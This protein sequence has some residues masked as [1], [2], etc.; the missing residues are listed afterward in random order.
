MKIIRNIIIIFVGGIL[1]L[2]VLNIGNSILATYLLRLDHP[3]NPFKLIPQK[4][5]RIGE[6]LVLISQ[7]ID[8]AWLTDFIHSVGL[9][10]KTAKRLPSTHPLIVPYEWISKANPYPP[11]W[12][13]VYGTEQD[14]IYLSFGYM[15]V[16]QQYHQI[17]YIQGE[18]DTTPSPFVA[19]ARGRSTHDGDYFVR[20]TFYFSKR[21]TPIPLLTD[22]RTGEVKQ[23]KPPPNYPDIDRIDWSTYTGGSYDGF[24][25]MDIMF[26]ATMIEGAVLVIGGICFLVHHR[27]SHKSKPQI[28]LSTDNGIRQEA[29]E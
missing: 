25:I 17:T 2:L 21:T 27:I 20:Y 10:E 8:E 18:T 7:H 9:D 28:R 12:W 1:V 5:T 4:M 24:E 15:G 14:A 26:F 11:L 13:D 22:N 16:D 6:P 3:T 19:K 23:W 29:Y